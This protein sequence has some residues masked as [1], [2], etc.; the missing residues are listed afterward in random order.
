MQHDGVIT[1][2]S[3]QLKVHE[4]NYPTHDLELAA[5][6]FALKIWRNYLYGE[7]CMI[8]T[9]QKSPKKTAVINQF[10]VQRLL[11]TEIQ[12]FV[13]VVYARDNASNLSTLTV[14]TTFRDM[15]RA[16]QTS[17]EQLQKLRKRDEAKGQMLYIFVDNRVRYRDRLWV[18]SNGSLRAIS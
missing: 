11:Q 14:Q 6:V 13:L 3:R 12:R 16:G 4:Q 15:I 18:P 8:F 17:D 5:L 10:S 2:A 7:K 1:Y 9:D